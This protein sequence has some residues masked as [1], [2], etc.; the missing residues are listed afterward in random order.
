M[1]SRRATPFNIEIHRDIE[2]EPLRGYPPFEE[3]MKPKG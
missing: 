3:L 1:P 2:I